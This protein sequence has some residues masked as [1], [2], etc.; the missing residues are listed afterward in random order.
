[1]SVANLTIRIV[2]ALLAFCSCSYNKKDFIEINLDG[3]V[4][5]V[6]TKKYDSYWLQETSYISKDKKKHSLVFSCNVLQRIMEECSFKSENLLNVTASC[7]TLPLNKTHL[8]FSPHFRNQA[9]QK[10][11]NLMHYGGEMYSLND[12]TLVIAFQL[13]GN[14][15]L[16]NK[17]CENFIQNR[18]LAHGDC[19]IPPNDLSLPFIVLS[20]IK[21]TR[22]LS[23][24]EIKEQNLSSAFITEFPLNVCE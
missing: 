11:E 22:S 4:Q 2:I 1:M 17:T 12:T 7:D 6:Y 18:N 13:I 20:Y 10:S 14:G 21:E 15:V 8:F 9:V 19:P 23:E 3:Q 16:F 24:Q 5:F